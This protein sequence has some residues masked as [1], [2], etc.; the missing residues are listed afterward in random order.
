[1]CTINESSVARSSKH[2]R[3]EKCSRRRRMSFFGHRG[4]TART[5]LDGMGDMMSEGRGTEC[6]TERVRKGGT[7]FL[8]TVP[9]RNFQESRRILRI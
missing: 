5:L 6:R 1:M 3:Q 8:S 7:I 9:N 4:C 2:Y